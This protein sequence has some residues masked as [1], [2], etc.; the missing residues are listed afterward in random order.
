MKNIALEYLEYNIQRCNC[1]E[2]LPFLQKNKVCLV[3]DVPKML[4][5]YI[6]E[7]VARVDLELRDKY[8]FIISYHAPISDEILANYKKH[9]ALGG[10][11]VLFNQNRNAM[12]TFSNG[13]LGMED[14]LDAAK[15]S[16]MEL[17][18]L[19]KIYQKNN[20]N[21]DIHLYFPYPDSTLMTALFSDKR[22]PNANEFDKGARNIIGDRYSFFNESVFAARLL[23]KGEFPYFAN[24]FIAVIG[25]DID[26][27]Y[28]RYSN[29]RSERYQIKTQ[30]VYKDMYKIIKKTP[31]TEEAKNHLE[32]MDKNADLLT[33]VYESEDFKIVPCELDGE[34]NAYFPYIEGITLAKVM[35]KL[36]NEGKVEAILALFK[37]FLNYITVK[38]TRGIT[39][40]DFIFA[41]I[42]IMDE[43]WYA[44][45]YEWVIEEELEARKLAL[46]AAY[47]FSLE[48][49]NFPIHQLVDFFEYTQKDVVDI[50]E[51][52]REFQAKVTDGHL[53]FEV[54]REEMKVKNHSFEDIK[55][56][57]KLQSL[58]A[59]TQ[60]YFDFGE[61]FSEE[62]SKIIDKSKQGPTQI[63]IDEM[64][65]EKT[66]RLRIDPD[67]KQC[68]FKITNIE[69]N[70]RKVDITQ[71]FENSGM[72]LKNNIYLFGTN[73]PYIIIDIKACLEES[74]VKT[75][76]IRFLLEGEIYEVSEAGMDAIIDSINNVKTTYVFPTNESDIGLFDRIKRKIS[77][78]K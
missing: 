54:F 17:Q 16:Y 70:N 24:E 7:K 74:G 46:R 25:R 73:D 29:D 69:I 55:R 52:E 65:M 32:M 28:I 15:L 4:W 43:K 48:Q 22:L 36:S 75:E 39:N 66:Q 57:E 13:E 12:T 68:I 77:S 61:G 67:N 18:Q 58:E 50:I 56:M 19:G 3:G 21:D 30:I 6:T 78:L 26:A 41:N 9:L 34:G 10:R 23:E 5:G 60:L 35:A 38:D 37:Q 62:N 33:K 27:E 49:K 64:I 44:I 45:D 20:I 59:F 76:E 63:V 2:W 14:Y 8:D 71:E 47:C 72:L 40:Y 51:R 31:L 42:I 1:I 11:I 53:S